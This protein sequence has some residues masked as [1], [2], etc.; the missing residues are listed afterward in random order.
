MTHQVTILTDDAASDWASPLAKCDDNE[1]IVAIDTE[2]D[3][4]KTDPTEPKTRAYEDVLSI[5]LVMYF[6]GRLC[7]VFIKRELDSEPF[8]FNDCLKQIY[9]FANKHSNIHE[10]FTAEKRLLNNKK[11]PDATPL[12][13]SF[14]AYWGGVDYSAMKD[15]EKV[16]DSGKVLAVNK[17]AIVTPVDMAVS[18]TDTPHKRRLT[19]TTSMRDMLKWAPA[20]SNLEK[21]GEMLHYPKLNTEAWDK[22]DGNVIGH[23][24]GHMSELW[25]RRPDDFI[26]YAMRDSDI[27]LMYYASLVG[28]TGMY[29][30]PSSASSYAA[31]LVIAELESRHV[32]GSVNDSADFVD[33]LKSR[34]AL[35]YVLPVQ[36]YD[37]NHKPIYDTQATIDQVRP[38]KYNTAFWR[39]VDAY[40]GGLNVAYVSGYIGNA[41]Y[42]V[43]IDLEGSYNTNGH[44]IPSLRPSAR[45]V[46]TA[47]GREIKRSYTFDA[48]DDGTAQSTIAK[49]YEFCSDELNGVYTVG[50]C[51]ATVEWPP[52][53]QFITTPHRRNDLESPVYVRS[54]GVDG[55]DSI[56][57]TLTLTDVLNAFEA[58]AKIHLITL[59]ICPQSILAQ[60]LATG[61]LN[62]WGA[63]QDQMAKQ[64]ATAIANGDTFGN[65]F[66]KLVGNVVYGKTGQGLHRKNTRDF[67]SNETSLEPLSSISEPFQAAQYTALTRYHLRVLLDAIDQVVPGRHF[68]QS[69]TTD[70]VAIS[71]DIAF[72]DSEFSDFGLDYYNQKINEAMKDI[73]SPVYKMAVNKYFNGRCFKFKGLSHTTA[74]TLKTRV[75]GTRDRTLEAL[76][77]IN[78]KTATDVVTLL[79]Q[80]VSKIVNEQNRIINIVEMKHSTKA[81]HLLSE[82]TQFVTVALGFDFSRLPTTFIT[83]Q[84]GL[85]YYQT[86]P[87]ETQDQLLTYKAAFTT[88]LKTDGY[89]IYTTTAA[90][91]FLATISN[92]GAGSLHLPKKFD[93]TYQVRQLGRAL[94]PG[95]TDARA[96][97]DKLVAIGYSA[98]WRNFR[99]LVAQEVDVTQIDWMSVYVIEQKIDADLGLTPNQKSDQKTGAVFQNRATRI[100]AQSQSYQRFASRSFFCIYGM[101]Q[102]CAPDDRDELSVMAT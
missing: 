80:H 33:D 32:G 58:G 99:K 65:Q 18:Y 2:W 69:A 16:L 8:Y 73:A 59:D 23:Y 61:K 49:L 28:Q 75:N 50:V 68:M 76:A 74:F 72:A 41:M 64:R 30:L 100:I 51:T 84:N 45:T 86:Q 56:A 71:S 38:T 47:S 81:K 82:K 94:P 12:K 26:D 4:G 48:M 22:Q 29:P 7:R 70:G 54:V 44:L 6:R 92:F 43:D 9:A 93:L 78:G 35:G 19:F 62:A 36:Y 66:Y 85:G 89:Y 83:T 17:H 98:T 13:L 67:E 87:F 46:T 3:S 91:F 101:S 5:Q 27:T 55:E 31:K 79:E 96:V 21:I 37:K 34:A 40:Y 90:P 14:I 1:A 39:A 57:D 53:A 10:H 20:G 102:K 42:T 15:W 52:D 24:K 95:F 25:L 60:D 88:M 63:V 77:S 11:Y 97:Y